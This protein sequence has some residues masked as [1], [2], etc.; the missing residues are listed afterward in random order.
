MT[1]SL[2]HDGEGLGTLGLYEPKV[3]KLSAEAGFG[4]VRRAPLENPFN[5]L[6]EIRP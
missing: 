6:D 3:R 2:A 1:T 4:R 5:I